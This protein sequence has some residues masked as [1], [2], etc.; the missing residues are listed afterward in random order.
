MIWKSVPD[1]GYT[2]N[3]SCTLQLISMCLW[4]LML[5]S[6]NW[7]M[8]TNILQAIPIYENLIQVEKVDEKKEKLLYRLEE[9]LRNEKSLS[10]EWK[11]LVI[12]PIICEILRCLSWIRK[13]YCFNWWNY[14]YIFTVSCMKIHHL[15]Y[16]QK[17]LI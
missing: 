5:I 3:V 7:N 2:R 8:T 16:S 4:S 15:S 1:V 10:A 11:S 12:K 13:W 6:L 9:I 14:Q 17:S